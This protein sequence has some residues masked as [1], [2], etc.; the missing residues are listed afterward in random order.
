MFGLA[1]AVRRSN[2]TKFSLLGKQNQ[3]GVNDEQQDNAINELFGFQ[4]HNDYRSRF[5]SLTHMY[6]CTQTYTHTVTHAHTYTH[7]QNQDN[8]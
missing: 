8:D 7:T 1:H 5:N 6:P 4:I 3:C 2:T